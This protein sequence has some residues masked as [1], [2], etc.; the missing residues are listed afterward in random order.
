MKHPRSAFG[1]RHLRQ[2]RRPFEAVQACAGRLG[3]AALSP[4]RGARPAAPDRPAAVWTGRAVA[5]SGSPAACKAHQ[6]PGEAG[7]AVSLAFAVRF[8][9]SRVARSAMDH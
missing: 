8:H 3:A 9:M 2:R 1:A 6:R 7:S 5:A 4:S